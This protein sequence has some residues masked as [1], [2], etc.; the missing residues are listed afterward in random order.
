MTLFEIVGLYVALNLF[1]LAT[2]TLRVGMVRMREKINLGDGGN[3]KM[4]QRIRA[5]GNYTESA[6]FALIGLFILAALSVAPFVL[7]IF[8]LMFLIGRIL[9]AAGM[10]A[11]NAAGKGRVIGMILTL[12]TLL[13]EAIS[14]LYLIFT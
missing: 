14:I 8:G 11:K 5:H 10:D 1:L 6:P 13:G 7:H 3:A 12:L 9:H 2:L 4:N